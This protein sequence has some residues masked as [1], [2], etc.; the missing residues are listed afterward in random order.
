VISRQLGCGK[1]AGTR[2]MGITWLAPL[3][4]NHFAG[5]ALFW[6]LTVPLQPA[7]KFD[8]ITVV[9]KY[10][11]AQDILCRGNGNKQLFYNDNSGFAG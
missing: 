4:H 3:V 6:P 11:R 5:N 1:E 7:G 9:H 10:F 2:Y 8:V